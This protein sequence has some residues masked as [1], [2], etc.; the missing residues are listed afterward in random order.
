MNGPAPEC[1]ACRV[2]MEEGYALSTDK[3]GR[4]KQTTWTEGPLE[5]GGMYGFK[6]KDK[7]QIPVVTWR[8]P[9]C[10]WLLWFA[11]EPEPEAGG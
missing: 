5:R 3:N 11:P 10:G 8:C 1:P 7:R 4:L 9:R 2:R 6:V